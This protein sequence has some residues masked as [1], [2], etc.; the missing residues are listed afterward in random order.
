MFCQQTN[1]S[2][3]FSRKKER[4]K[5]KVEDREQSVSVIALFVLRLWW[6]CFFHLL[7]CC[8]YFQSWVIKICC[9]RFC[10]LGSAVT[11]E[12]C[13]TWISEFC[14]NNY[15]TWR[16]FCWYLL[17]LLND[18][19]PPP[20]W[21][22]RGGTDWS[23]KMEEDGPVK[24][25]RPFLNYSTTSSYEDQ[26]LGSSR[27]GNHGVL[28][29]ASSHGGLSYARARS[30]LRKRDLQRTEEAA[31][32]L[33]WKAFMWPVTKVRE[34]EKFKTPVTL[35]V[36]A[37]LAALVAGLLCFAPGFLR[38]LNKNGVWAVITVD[39]VLEMNVGLT[40]SKG[41]EKKTHF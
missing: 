8:C 39:I 23:W 12:G 1:S 9:W 24:L 15:T 36:K 17:F 26:L 6:S 29:A 13:P 18:L 10:F 33:L 27:T 35:P 22:L 7:C 16:R 19:H 3:S 14:N 38:P 4:K 5:A 37:G 21:Q 34:I 2:R 40:F 11:H 25:S 32:S 31:A 41:S 28:A 30:L 20:P